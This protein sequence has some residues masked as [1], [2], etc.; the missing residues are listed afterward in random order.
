MVLEFEAVKRVTLG[1]RTTIEGDEDFQWKKQNKKKDVG[2]GE[3][4]RK[5]STEAGSHVD[6]LCWHGCK[7]FR[8]SSCGVFLLIL[9][10]KDVGLGR[11]LVCL[12]PLWLALN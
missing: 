6:K 11:F 10:E 7:R 12:V 8:R 4:K 5:R 9:M 2:S 1:R 3:S